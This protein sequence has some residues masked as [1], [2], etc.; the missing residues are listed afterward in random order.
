ML[1]EGGNRPKPIQPVSQA[2]QWVFPEHTWTGISH[3]DLDLFAAIALVAMNRA[4]GAG[5]FFSSKSAPVQSQPGIVHQ[6]F[7][8]VAKVVTMVIAAINKNHGLDGLEFACKPRVALMR[9]CSG[10]DTGLV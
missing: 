5:R 6:A 1:L 10:F 2:E 4:L 3:D 7:A 8:F 9:E